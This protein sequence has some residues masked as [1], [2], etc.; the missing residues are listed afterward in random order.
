[1][2]KTEALIAQ[3]DLNPIRVYKGRGCILVET[4]EGTYVIEEFS[5][6]V[7]RIE[8]EEVLLHELAGKTAILTPRIIRTREQ[9]L[10]AKDRDLRQYL[11]KTGFPGKECSFHEPAELRRCVEILATL[12]QYM[13]HQ[14]NQGKRIYHLEEEILRHNRDLVKCRKFLRMRGTLS[15]FELKLLQMFDLFSVQASEVSGEIKE[16]KLYQYEE[17]QAE[18]GCYCH[19]DFQYHNVIFSGNK[20]AVIQFEKWC[21]DVHIRDFYHFFRKVME[22][23]NWDESIGRELIE[24]YFTGADVS[25]EEKRI[26]YYRLAYPEKFW[27]IVHFY[28]YHAKAFVSEKNM[29]KCEKLLQQEK[30]R[31]IFLRDLKIDIFS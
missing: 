16:A 25:T 21:F 26:F 14:I 18:K 23:Y 11:C 13:Y 12:S 1:M 27:K 17:K 6:P 10:L 20:A 30:N 2:D 22:K 5:G 28:M 7:R 9:E 15:D 8:M 3:Y 24:L 31:Q 19:G 29:E 4:K